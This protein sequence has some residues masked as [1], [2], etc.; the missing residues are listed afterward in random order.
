MNFKPQFF[1]RKKT[2]SKVTPLNGAGPAV[3]GD[4]QSLGQNQNALQKKYSLQ[5]SKPQHSIPTH[6]MSPSDASILD[7]K[8]S[9]LAAEKSPF[10]NASERYADID[11]AKHEVITQD[12]RHVKFGASLIS[13]KHWR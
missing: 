6:H 4:I 9:P 11:W 3:S 10:S 5:R 13:N 1:S 2:V 7:P 12:G 8:N